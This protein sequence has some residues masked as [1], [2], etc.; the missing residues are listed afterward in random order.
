MVALKARSSEDYV[1]NAGG[2]VIGWI[3]GSLTNSI[4]FGPSPVG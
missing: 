3:H 2:P 4:Q 1:R